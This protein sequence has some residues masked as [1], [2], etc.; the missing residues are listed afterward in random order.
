MEEI[1]SFLPFAEI[2]NDRCKSA[3]TTE[4]AEA[5]LKLFERISRSIL[6]SSTETILGKKAWPVRHLKLIVL[7]P[8]FCLKDQLGEVNGYK[9]K[10]KK[11]KETFDWCVKTEIWKTVLRIGESCNTPA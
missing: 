5:L 10:L 9:E 7:Q 4:T 1:A 8:G 3:V 6:D 2:P 11:L